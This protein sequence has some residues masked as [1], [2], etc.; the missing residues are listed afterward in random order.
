MAS[1]K[2][3][4]QQ[5]MPDGYKEL[6]SSLA[7]FFVRQAGNSFEG[8]LRGSFTT[9]GKFGDRRVYRIEVAD[10]EPIVVSKDNPEPS[11]AAIGEIIGVDETGYLKRLNDL[12]DGTEVFLRCVGKGASEKDPWIFQVGVKK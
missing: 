12:E 6:S 8:V 11:E 7:G 5:P 1:K 10:G 4:K 3:A 9:K 2:A